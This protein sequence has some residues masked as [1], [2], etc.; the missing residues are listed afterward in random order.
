[1]IYIITQNILERPPHVLRADCRRSKV[2]CRFLVRA[3]AKTERANQRIRLRHPH[4]GRS[5]SDR[6]RARRSRIDV[7]VADLGCQD[8]RPT[9]PAHLG[10]PRKVQA[11]HRELWPLQRTRRAW[12]CPECAVSTPPSA[13]T[14]T[15]TLPCMRGTERASGRRRMR[16]LQSHARSLEPG[17]GNHALHVSTRAVLMCTRHSHVC[18][19]GW[20]GR[21]R[22]WRVRASACHGPE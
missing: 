18:T 14:S 9:E 20:R 22:E 16:T 17:V 12:R 21:T 11:D 8:M 3:A 10:R 6:R 2:N 1:M 13:R 19:R 5:C 7:S 15:A 4:N